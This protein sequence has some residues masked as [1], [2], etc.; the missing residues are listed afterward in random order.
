M[1][2]EPSVMRDEFQRTLDRI[3]R[4]AASLG[5][6]GFVIALLIRGPRAAGGFLVGA[7]ISALSLES[8]KRF[9]RGLDASG[10]KRPGAS[11][12]FLGARYLI[13]GAVIYVIVRVTGINLG[14]VFVGL[15]VSLA[16]VLL[17]FLYELTFR[18]HS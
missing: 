17:N 9:A 14:A 15:L 8:W 4:L 12:V 10:T 13:A 18:N 6:A 11:A 1:S 16:G 5:L 7:A 2:R 3:L